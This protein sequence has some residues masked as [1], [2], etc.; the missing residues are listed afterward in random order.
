MGVFSEKGNGVSENRIYPFGLQKIPFLHGR[1]EKE[2]SICIEDIIIY[3]DDP[4][5]AS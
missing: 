3:M 2:N 4:K 5:N 1:K